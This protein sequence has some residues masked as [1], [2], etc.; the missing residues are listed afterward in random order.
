METATERSEK[1]RINKL[2][3]DH[4]RLAQFNK[5]RLE[6]MLPNSNS[7]SD[8]QSDWHR[9]VE[10][11]YQNR[12]LERQVLEK[13]R[14]LIAAQ[15]RFAPREPKGF[16]Q[17]FEGLKK[18]GPGQNSPL[19]PWLAEKSNYEEMKWFIQQE[20]AGEAGFE[21]LTA[22]TQIKIPRRA[23]L[24]M[25]RNYWDEMGRGRLAGMH[26]PMLA[27]VAEEFELQNADPENV[28]PEAIALGNIMLGLA[29]NRAYAYHSIGALG[30]I[31]LTAPGRAVK[32]YEG[33][34]RLG[35]SHEAQR[36]YLLH[37]SLDIKHSAEWNREVLAPLVKENPEVAVPIA[38][39]ALMRLN[40][41]ARCFERYMRHFGLTRSGAELASMPVHQL[42]DAFQKLPRQVSELSEFSTQHF[43]AGRVQM[44]G[45]DRRGESRSSSRE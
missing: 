41:G 31:E 7:Q 11:D 43:P 14:A 45:P 1:F 42:R 9:E 5:H 20:V 4:L 10:F 17:W 37:S 36:Y 24:E 8:W 34:K 12:L 39:G 30:V 15:A 22:L 32:V 38:E 2:W 6:P 35:V 23:K 44:N 29:M 33:L 13:E 19:F 28:I 25:A 40:A 18:T 21:D 26:G 16:V 3:E 27:R